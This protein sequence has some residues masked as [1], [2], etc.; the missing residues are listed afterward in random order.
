MS[1]PPTREF[2]QRP[3]SLLPFVPLFSVGVIAANQCD[4]PISR[5][6]TSTV[7]NN[8]RSW[9]SIYELQD[10]CCLLLLLIAALLTIGPLEEA[11]ASRLVVHVAN[12]IHEKHAHVQTQ[13]SRRRRFATALDFTWFRKR[14][15]DDGVTTPSSTIDVGEATIA[16]ISTFIM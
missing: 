13:N 15:N 5:V 4:D 2:A 9:S 1:I 12:G 6:T 8:C 16:S 14:S 7:G 3:S 11:K 10:T